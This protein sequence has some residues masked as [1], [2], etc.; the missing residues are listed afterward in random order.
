MGTEAA[1]VEYRSTLFSG[2]EL[3]GGFPNK[4]IKPQQRGSEDGTICSFCLTGFQL[5]GDMKLP[6]AHTGA[7]SMQCR[8]ERLIQGMKTRLTHVLIHL[9]FSDHRMKWPSKKKLWWFL[10]TKIRCTKFCLLW[11]FSIS[12]KVKIRHT[13][14]SN[15]IHLKEYLVKYL[16]APGIQAFFFN[17]FS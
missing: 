14:S 16:S 6:V 17:N 12:N 13:G 8:S 7:D 1:N 3:S 11:I 5:S 9:N 2:T 10:K 15:S 4:H